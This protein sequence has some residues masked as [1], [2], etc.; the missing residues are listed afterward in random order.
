MQALVIDFLP[1]CIFCLCVGALLW[2]R[3]MGKQL[4]A[5][6][7]V[8]S[9]IWEPI[10]IVQNERYLQDLVILGD[11]CYCWTILIPE[12]QIFNQSNCSLALLYFSWTCQTPLPSKLLFPML[13]T[14]MNILLEVQHREKNTIWLH[15]MEI[16]AVVWCDWMELQWWLQIHL[17]FLPW[18]LSL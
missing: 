1:F 6:N 17:I 15:E 7:R 18:I 12:R 3:L 8:D 14:H 2:H 13:E 5:T 16:S 9:H 11:F 4:L 10:L